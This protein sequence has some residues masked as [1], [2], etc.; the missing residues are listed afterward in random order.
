MRTRELPYI[1]AYTVILTPV[2]LHIY[3]VIQEKK[4]A[5]CS[6]QKSCNKGKWVRYLLRGAKKM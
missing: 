4:P 1:Q 3:Y 2:H 6:G 5:F